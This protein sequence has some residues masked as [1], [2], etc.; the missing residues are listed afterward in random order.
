MSAFGDYIKDDCF[1]SIKNVVS[2]IA[3]ENPDI[4]MYEILE[5]TMEIITY[6]LKIAFYDL[7]TGRRK[8]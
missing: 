1:E 4:P 5:E 3:D 7:E 6:S 8:G 2:H